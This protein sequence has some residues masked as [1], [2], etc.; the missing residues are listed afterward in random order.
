MKENE[1]DERGKRKKGMKIKKGKKKIKK[2]K[3]EILSFI[4][5]KYFSLFLLTV[6]PNVCLNKKKKNKSNE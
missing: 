4:L 1:S 6:S 5:Y 2:G 3:E